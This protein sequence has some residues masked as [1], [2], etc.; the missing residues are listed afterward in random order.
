MIYIENCNE[1]RRDGLTRFG[2]SRSFKPPQSLYFEK[3]M[4]SCQT[5]FLRFFFFEL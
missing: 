2:N 5:S 3:K 4:V 1:V